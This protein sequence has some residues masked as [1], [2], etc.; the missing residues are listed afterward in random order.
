MPEVELDSF[1]VNIDEP[2]VLFI[3]PDPTLTF[4]DPDKESTNKIYLEPTDQISV[5][6]TESIS[7]N[8]KHKTKKGRKSKSDQSLTEDRL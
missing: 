6:Q 1:P 8:T 4:T 3:Q 2:N 7:E 5:V